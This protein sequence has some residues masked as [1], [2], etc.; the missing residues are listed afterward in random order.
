MALTIGAASAAPT[1]AL[2]GSLLQGRVGD[3]T[4]ALSGS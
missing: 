4:A 2:S 3:P 1:A